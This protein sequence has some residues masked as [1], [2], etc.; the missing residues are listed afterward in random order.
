MTETIAAMGAKQISF[1]K[2][3]TELHS[4]TNE[5]RGE[6]AKIADTKNKLKVEINLS[7]KKQRLVKQNTVLMEAPITAIEEEKPVSKPQPIE[8]QAT[9]KVEK[10]E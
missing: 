3:F 4:V 10:V 9:Q 8:T 6:Q 2:H 1:A 7:K 5:L